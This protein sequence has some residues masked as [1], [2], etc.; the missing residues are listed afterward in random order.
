MP[1]RFDY[2]KKESAA[3]LLPNLISHFNC[4][5]VWLTVYSYGPFFTLP[6]AFRCVLSKLCTES[7]ETI[8]RLVVW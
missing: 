4:D 1:I 6:S 7:V 3:L 2:N 8:S 5:G